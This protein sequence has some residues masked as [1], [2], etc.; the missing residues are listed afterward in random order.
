MMANESADC[1]ALFVG[2]HGQSVFKITRIASGVGYRKPQLEDIV[3][4]NKN[5]F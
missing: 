4:E 5:G 3:I 2:L 1:A